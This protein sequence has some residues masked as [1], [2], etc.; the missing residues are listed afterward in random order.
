MRALVVIAALSLGV[1]G[2]GGEAPKPVAAVAPLDAGVLAPAPRSSPGRLEAPVGTVTLERDGRT[3]PAL[4]EPLYAHDVIDTGPDS[5]AVLRFGGDRVVELGPEGRFEVEVGGSGVMLTV[6]QGLVLTRVRA[7]PGAAGGGDVLI[8]LSTP[9]GL[10]RVGSAEVSLKVDDRGADVDVTLGEI[11][12]VSKSGEVTRLGAGKK[13]QLGQ[14]RELP[15]IPLT[16]V[17]SSGKAELRARDAKSFVA[18]NPKKPPRLAAGDT[19]RVKE[20]RFSLSPEG[21]QTRVSLLKGAEVGIVESRKGAGR[22]ATALEVRKGE[23]EVVAPSGQQTRLAVGAGVTLVSDLG[24][25]FSLR[26]TGSGFDVDALAGDVT[27]EREGEASTVIPG[28]QSASVPLKGASAVRETS[29]E[30]VVLPPRV[31]RLYHSGLKQVALAWDE[32]EGTTEW[33]V[34]LASDAA[35]TTIARDGVVHAAFVNVP[36][37]AKG[38]WYW[39]VFKGDAEYARG[40]VSFSPE[41]RVQDL[42]RLKNVVPEG[43]ETT[44]IFFQDKDKPPVV[45]FTW[46][47]AEGAAKYAVKV[48]RDGQLASPV[49]ER[50]VVEAQVSLPENTLVEGKYLWSVT[51]LDGKGGELKGGRLNKLHMTFDNAVAS[52]LI[53]APRN[54]DVGGKSV[55][56]SGIAP[57]G[58][59]LSINGRNVTLDEQARFETSVA[60]LAGGRVVFRLVQGGA[61]S[62]T[63]RTVRAR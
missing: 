52:L 32:E 57:V 19:V 47:K 28:G 5:S 1:S 54:G 35:F 26:R 42:S 45:T 37:P 25:Q 59:R 9:F 23:L 20:G 44:T 55:R 7:T 24:G 50:T 11:E 34:Q 14:A 61:E 21:S 4:A 27:I 56:A 15:E 38:G 16:I 13:G 33:R 43:A 12:L 2:C 48:Y 53:K 46:A 36:V 39:R 60:P 30:A 8:S 63:V 51:P 6:T 29:R 58:S 10:T 18:I 3:R 49:A 22:E 31:V 62:W 17:A 40:Q 41:P